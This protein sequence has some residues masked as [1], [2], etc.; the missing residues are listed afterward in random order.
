MTVNIDLLVP[1]L[2]FYVLIVITTIIY[3]RTGRPLKQL[4]IS[5]NLFLHEKYF[6]S[7][8]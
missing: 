8:L 3:L 7:N 2:V 1:S 6:R 5:S 4:E